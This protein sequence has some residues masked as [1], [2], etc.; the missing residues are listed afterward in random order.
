M[1]LGSGMR[2][3]R[4]VS[5]L[6]QSSTTCPAAAGASAQAP[7]PTIARVI[8]IQA[9]VARKFCSR[10]RESSMDVCLLV[11]LE[12]RDNQISRLILLRALNFVQ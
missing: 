11:V 3:G 6:W 4:P 12:G 5:A 9:A 7:R 1:S 10:E 8:K 2:G